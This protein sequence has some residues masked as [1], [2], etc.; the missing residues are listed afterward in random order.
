MLQFYQEED[1][2]TTSRL[3]PANSEPIIRH[4]LHNKVRLSDDAASRSSLDPP[5]Q[6]ELTAKIL[7]FENPLKFINISKQGYV[8]LWSHNLQL[9]KVYSAAEDADDGVKN[10]LGNYSQARRRATMWIT[11]AVLM[12]DTHKLVL[13]STS[14]DLRFFTMTS[15]TFLEEFTVYGKMNSMGRIE[16]EPRVVRRYQKCPDVPRLLCK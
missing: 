10:L 4:I 7:H 13:S 5:F 12:P 8:G 3:L 6:Q 11:D 2:E 1:Y 14:R 16:I 15:E 9:E